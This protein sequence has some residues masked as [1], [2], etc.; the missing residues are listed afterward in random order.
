MVGL[1]ALSAAGLCGG[2]AVAA[3]LGL[4]AGVRVTSTF[5]L[6]RRL[7]L[8]RL[9]GVNPDTSIV[10]STCGPVR[11]CTA[12]RKMLSLLGA[13][14]GSGLAAEA[15]SEAGAASV[16]GAAGCGAG[17]G[18]GA[19]ASGTGSAAGL[20]TGFGAGLGL[21]ERSILPRI[22]AGQFVLDA[23]DVAFDNY[24]L[25]LFARLFLCLFEGDRSL[26]LGDSLPDAFPFVAGNSAPAEFLLQ[27]GIDVRFH[28]R[29]G[30]TVGFIPFFCRKS[31]MVFNPTLNSLATWI[32][33][34]FLS[35]LIYRF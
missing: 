31:V 10:P 7:R 9:P 24:L 15:V 20:L 6:L 18:F 33:L 19:A 16:L 14:S 5:S 13:A 8:W 3:R 34:N 1:R 22:W 30:R 28:Q 2:F 35:L 17:C 29:I 27:N 32:S 26:L 25:L 21:G 12:G 4:P 23:D 11:V